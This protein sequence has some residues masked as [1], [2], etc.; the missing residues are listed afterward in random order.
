MNFLRIKAIIAQEF[1]M[2]YRAIEILMDLVV[3]PVMSIVVF[4]F[5]SKYLTGINTPAVGRSVLMGML[6]WQFIWIT[7]YTVSFGS[8][9]NIWS[10][11]LSNL[12]VTPLTVKEYLFA[13]TM[14]GVMKGLFIL[15]LSSLLSVYIFDFNLLD[16]GLVNLVLIIINLSLFAFSLGV[17]ILGLIFRFGTRIQA[18]AWGFLPFF[19]PITAAF[20]PVHVLPTFLQ[21]VAYMLPPTY[22]FEVARQIL[23]GDPIDYGYFVMAFTINIVYLTLAV[24]FF[25]YL[26]NKSKESG[27]FA[28]NEG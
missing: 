6:L 12:F 17:G 25:H 20:Y 16:I 1:Y 28:R 2:S 15:F 13:Q 9:W 23:G 18:F 14:S 21:P 11:N 27:Q 4:G 7:Q 10:R 8:L 5:L 24:S 3:F 26:Y 19:Q 22:M